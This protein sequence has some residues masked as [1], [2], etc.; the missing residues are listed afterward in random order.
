M[1]KQ[2][3]EYNKALKNAKVHN[4]KDLVHTIDKEKLSRAYK[5]YQKS[6]NQICDITEC[7]F[8]S[9]IKYEKWLL[10]E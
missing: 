8:D 10:G 3:K 1:K 4:L 2:I 9:L 5:Q 7:D 6:I